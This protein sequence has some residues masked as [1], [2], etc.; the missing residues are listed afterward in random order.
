MK[1]GG[2]SCL[3]SSRAGSKVANWTQTPASVTY[4]S[5][6]AY[7]RIDHGLMP[8]AMLS[9][10]L[11]LVGMLAA[12]AAAPTT[13]NSG[14]SPAVAPSVSAADKPTS[15][16]TATP[17]SPVLPTDVTAL[18][19]LSWQQSA[20]IV[21]DGQVRR[22]VGEAGALWALGF[23]GHTS[24]GLGGAPVI[25]RS[26]DGAEWVQTSLPIPE[27][28]S[29]QPP[30]LVEVEHLAAHDD[31]LVALGSISALDNSTAVA[32]QSSDGEGWVE[33]NAPPVNFVTDVTSGPGGLV[34]T[35]RGYGQ[36]T[37]G[38]WLSADAGLTWLETTPSQQVAASAIVGTR[39]HYVLAGADLGSDGRARP[40]IWTSRD[41]RTWSPAEVA[42]EDGEGVVWAVTVD[43]SGRWVGVGML[44]TAAATWRSSDGASWELTSELAAAGDQPHAGTLRLTGVEE[45]FLIVDVNGTAWSS[46]DGA[47]WVGVE[48]WPR[49]DG[50]ESAGG[51][52]R[53]EDRIVL[54]HNDAPFT[55][56][57]AAT[58]AWTVWVATRSP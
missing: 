5:R 11:V 50:G 14:S 58:E 24:S 51:I 16:P 53:I 55:T 31:R 20:H 41:G 29:R 18:D 1:M 21:G 56:G 13:S 17:T 40:A 38:V 34:V 44:G 8:K 28:A 10:T 26:D 7:P 22:V 15:R 32:W 36:G 27:T 49:P 25:W 37:G 52:A 33:T 46:H 6:A 45:G 4:R 48:P 9:T 42:N 12:C 39:D 30:V 2:G 43:G 47:V 54:V 57:S 19:T 35:G 23:T 3:S